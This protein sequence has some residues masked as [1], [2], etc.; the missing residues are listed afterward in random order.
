MTRKGKVA[1]RPRPR[2]APDA[3]GP[4]SS[5]PARVQTSRAATD[6]RKASPSRSRLY[7]PIAI[8]YAVVTAVILVVFILVVR[9]LT[10][11]LALESVDRQINTRGI[12]TTLILSNTIEPF[13]L[14][15]APA[16]E[17]AAA[18]HKLTERL[19]RLLDELKDKD[20]LDL[21]VIDDSG[22]Q[23]V[24]IASQ[25]D[26]RS[27]NIRLRAER[28]LELPEDETAA[29]TI[30]DGYLGGRRARS[31]EHAILADG[32][33]A[34][35][36]RVFLSA[37]K[38]ESLRRDLEQTVTWLIIVALLVA[39]PIVTLLGA[40]LTRPVRVLK[41]DMAQVSSGQLNH[42][43]TVR[44][45]DELELLAEAF[46][47][48]T[49]KLAEAK[50]REATQR[51]LERELSIATRIQASLLPTG[52]PETPGYEVKP[53]YQSAKEV[54]GDYYDFLLREDGRLLIVVAD[55]AGKGIPASLVMTMTRSLVRMAARES[56]S[57]KAMLTQ[58]NR[59]LARDMTRGMFVTLALVEIDLTTG[60]IQLLRAGHNP[61]LWCSQREQR[62]RS[63]QP[64][65]MALGMPQTKF[66][67][68]LEVTELTLDPGDLLILYT[69]GITEA[70]SREGREYTSERLTAI[71]EENAR[72]PAADILERVL[73]DVQTHVNGAE[74]SDDITLVVI[75]RE[76]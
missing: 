61:P 48:M 16:S 38:I 72:H 22:E 58:V 68:N 71:V 9:R 6:L 63:L 12:S 50:D 73:G 25:G 24:A 53:Y 23:F 37:E 15:K 5:P 26:R 4:R 51:A 62:V 52:V 69:D 27:R 57:P 64:A 19:N 65:G 31:Y 14:S 54:G 3:Q 75:R 66:E 42:K 43:S 56:V 28:A 21:L 13:W 41:N 34:G 49:D 18:Q 39:V 47:R 36:L 40:L 20:F 32:Q 76:A 2:P 46:N 67:Q 30:F 55:V 7:I 10:L 11:D 17:K 59:T 33:P 44:S 60:A 70:M 8:K 1:P 29:V 74:P 45:G 35:L